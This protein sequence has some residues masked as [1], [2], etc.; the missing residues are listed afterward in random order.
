MY[1]DSSKILTSDSRQI[2]LWNLDLELTPSLITAYE[3]EG[4]LDFLF[5]RENPV[6]KEPYFVLVR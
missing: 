3:I 1:D 5:I 6:G 4:L 2:K